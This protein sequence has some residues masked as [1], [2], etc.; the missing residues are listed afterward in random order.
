MN[1]TNK[2]RDDKA[3]L[4]L[5]FSKYLPVRDIASALQIDELEARNL[6]ARGMALAAGTKEGV[7]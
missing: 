3:K 5:A 1:H 4:A 7:S 6:V 2:D